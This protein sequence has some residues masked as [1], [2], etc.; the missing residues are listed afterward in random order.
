MAQAI[1]LQTSGSQYGCADGGGGGEVKAT[2]AR[3]A[4]WESFDLINPVP[5]PP[6]ADGS[7]IVIQTGDAH[8][9]CPGPDRRRSVLMGPLGVKRPETS[10]V[11]P[12]S[13]RPR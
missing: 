2:R 4:Q 1:T 5:G 13:R 12:C 8:F 10:S 7:K 11:R 9:F 6:V 3:P